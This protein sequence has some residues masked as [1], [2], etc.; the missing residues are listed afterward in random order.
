VKHDPIQEIVC[1]DETELL[2][3]VGDNTDHDLATVDGKKTHHGLGS[4]AIA[5]GKFPAKKIARASVPRDRKENW[6]DL[7]SNEGIPI[8]PYHPPDKTALKKTILKPI[9]S[10]KFS[11]CFTNLLWTCAHVFT[12]QCPSWSGYMSTIVTDQH[13]GKS[14]V[15]MLPIINLP[16]TDMTGLHS[17]LFFVTEQSSKLNVPT[18]TITFDQPLYVKAYEIVKSTKMNILV[19]LG[20]FHQ[21]MS[22]LG[23][24]G[25]MME[26]S[27]LKSALETVYAP[28]TV[29]HM[30]TGKAFSRAMRGH[31]LATAA[32]LTLIFE[33]F[34]LTMTAD[35]KTQLIKIY[36]SPNPSI[37]EHDEVS[38]KLVDWFTKEC[39]EL[40]T[41]SRTSALWLNYT[42]YVEIA[43][44]FTKADR[45]NDWLLHV[46][47][48]KQ[49]LNLFAA[50]GHNNYAKT[51][52]IY[53]DS[54]ETLEVDHPEIYEQF[55][56]GNHTVRRTEKSWSGIP[57][58]LS[59]E[60][61]L[62][63]SLKGRGG[64]IGKGMTDNVLNVWTK[65][66][67]R[68]AEVSE[69]VDEITSV[70][71]YK[72]KSA[73]V[74]K[75][76]S[77]YR[78][79]RDNED[80]QKILA[81]FQSHNPFATSD[82]LVCLNTGL[83]DER[84]IVTCDKAEEIGAIIQKTLD[85]RSF[86]DCSFKRTNQIKN[87]Q[88]LYSSISLENDEISIDPL[89]LFLRLAVA[90]ERKPETEIES[91][92]YY[93]LTPYPT[94]L[95]VG[96]KMRV[97]Q[98]ATLKNH[99]IKKVLHSTQE[100]SGKVV[101]D[102]G[103]LLWLC[104]W[105]KN[106]KFRTIF[107][108]YVAK[109]HSLKINIVVFDGYSKSTK[110]AT[111]ASR[112]GKSSEVVEICEDNFCPSDRTQFLNNYKNKE[113]FIKHLANTLQANGFEVILCPSD[114]DTTIVKTAL[115]IVGESVTVLADD[116]D[117]MILLIHHVYFKYCD[118]NIFLK[119]MTTH[120]DAGE[121]VKY[122]IN[123]IIASCDEIHIESILFAHA[124]TGSDTTSSIYRFG[125]TKILK[126]LKNS[127]ELKN[128]VEQFYA[129]DLTP[130][131]IGKATIRIF[132]L[133]YSPT[134]T[135]QQ[136]RR[137]KYEA[138]ISQDRS[139]IDPAILPPS[140]RAAFFHGL[141]VYH[142]IMVWKQL[143]NTDINPLCWGWQ[144]S[145]GDYVPIATDEAAGPPD[146]LKIIRCGCKVNCGN[147]CS[148]RKAGLK[149][150]SACQECQGTTC[151]NLAIITPE[152]ETEDVECE[153]NFMDAFIF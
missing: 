8:K 109:C 133:L 80:F 87:L 7:V 97:A 62:M 61:I 149:C 63:R 110:D 108:Q 24:I 65:T 1:P 36:E 13:L 44:Q 116:T 50:T 9:S 103:A 99:L 41:N 27:G 30:F 73:E 35:E 57:T 122:S 53:L 66:M 144:I 101:A 60:Q 141:R 104:N 59:I 121:R 74:H 19:R 2:Q 11:H 51:C 38:R 134:D 105:Q 76:M 106:E 98:K 124:F 119:N 55:I 47:T 95:F 45:T 21:L 52:R 39:E 151:T 43:K 153:R 5:N 31:M 152:P 22:F 140:P 15:T 90:I 125:K 37:Y 92:F 75:E 128:I 143:H 123:D 142:Q 94:S 150:T 40:S 126:N 135:L 70:D 29:N 148:C 42:K 120:K 10:K 26:G 34:W 146:L 54:I 71:K 115:E 112:S 14:Y 102:G 117:I 77:N 127:G 139:K 68:C 12:K 49:M 113:R 107:Q 91:Y 72:T 131:N 130:E 82:K 4:I 28:L 86:A 111:H 89:T 84:N 81:W 118:C 48:T 56:A 25:C 145:N 136:I 129:S 100:S 20:G 85:G 46:S 114:A 83:T 138:T 132:E 32:V 93:E 23:S 18:P 67:H 64:V 58:D 3:F 69:A 6:S 78:I 79:R 96:G 137:K 88:S 147:N 16:A 33:K 17:L